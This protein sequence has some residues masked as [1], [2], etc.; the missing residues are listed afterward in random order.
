MTTFEN[1]ADRDAHWDTFR[2][3]PYW[4]ELSALPQYQNN[5]SKSVTTFLYPTD[6][7]DL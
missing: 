2:T 7:S 3:D 5:V 1:K 6:Y 4:K